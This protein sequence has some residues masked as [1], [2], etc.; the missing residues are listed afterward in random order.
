MGHPAGMLYSKFMDLRKVRRIAIVAMFS[1]DDLMDKLVLKGGNALTFVYEF[2]TRAS[3]DIDLSI[4]GDF[5]SFEDA[6]QHIF[7]CLRDQFA[8]A[9]HLLFDESFERRPPNSQDQDWGGYLVEFKLIEKDLYGKLRGDLDTVR[10]NAMATGP[11]QRKIFRIELSKHEFCKGKIETELDAYT[12]YVYTPAMIAIEKLRALCQQMDE[13]KARIHKTARARDFYD[14]YTLVMQ[15]RI[16]LSSVENLELT[17]NIFAAKEVPLT[18][19][20]RIAESKEQHR[21]D[22]PSVEAAVTGPL[23]SFDAYFNFVVERIQSLEP[24]WIK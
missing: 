22:W 5:D 12:I 8:A 11:L 17:R 16:E 21:P 1:H 7:Q 23:L 14:I 2:G 3:L 15:A 10:R 18:L 9:G 20:P 24:L 4:D 19:I 6:K 13:Y